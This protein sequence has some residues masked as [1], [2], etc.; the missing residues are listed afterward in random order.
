M[1]LLKQHPLLAPTPMNEELP[2]GAGPFSCYSFTDYTSNVSSML[3]N[4]PNR[5][6]CLMH[7]FF[8]YGTVENFAIYPNFIRALAPASIQQVY[9]ACKL[10]APFIYRI[11]SKPELCV[12]IIIELYKSLATVLDQ[13]NA[14]TWAIGQEVP[15]DLLDPMNYLDT[16]TDFLIHAVAVYEGP[17]DVLLPTLRQLVSTMPPQLQVILQTALLRPTQP[18]PSQSAAAVATPGG[19]PPV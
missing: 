11:N 16:I 2:P 4:L 6:L 18:T 5:A 12:E 14:G 7:N 9:L 13:N 10:I 3:D 19:P 1:L 17:T 15:L 8:L